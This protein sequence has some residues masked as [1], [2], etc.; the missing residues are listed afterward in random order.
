MKAK[1]MVLVIGILFMVFAMRKDDAK[2]TF[3]IKK[4]NPATG[5]T[6]AWLLPSSKVQTIIGPKFKPLL[7]DGK[8]LLML[9][10]VTTKK[11]HLDNNSYDNLNLAHIIVPVEGTN[12]INS[13]HFMSVENQKINELLK[14]HGFNSETGKIKLVTQTKSDSIQLDAHII[15][16]KGSIEVQGTFLNKISEVKYIGST[17]VSAPGNPDRF[18][19]G[20][21]SYKRI[22]IPKLSIK[23]KGDTWIS[24][25]NLNSKP[26]IMWLNTNFVWDFLFN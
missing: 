4:D 5:L 16:N 3:V 20:S 2:H 12:A 19:R 10:I 17:T 25:L 24:Q 1:K 11:Y 14:N 18:F 8:G 21:E 22:D 23:I 26:D 15:S 9:F 7:K 13:P 6:L